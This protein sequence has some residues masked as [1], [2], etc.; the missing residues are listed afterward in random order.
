MRREGVEEVDSA[1]GV[2]LE[3]RARRAEPPEYRDHTLVGIDS[4]TASNS[5]YQYHRGEEDGFLASQPLTE[6]R[7]VSRAPAPMPEDEVRRIN[8]ERR[9]KMKGGGFSNWRLKRKGNKQEVIV[10]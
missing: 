10:R 8:E 9:R 7:S 2:G 1:G 3:G 6:Q 5:G 4:T